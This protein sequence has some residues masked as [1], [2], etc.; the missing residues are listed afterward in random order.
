MSNPGR[1]AGGRAFRRRD[2]ILALAGPVAD[3]RHQADRQIGD[4][5]PRQRP[6]Y[7]VARIVHAGVYT[8]IA[9]QGGQR[10]QG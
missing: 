10:M 1:L 5:D 6:D 8:G 2:A 9:H 3:T 7:D 4:C